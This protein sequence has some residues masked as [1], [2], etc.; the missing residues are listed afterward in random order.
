MNDKLR[1]ILL[2]VGDPQRPPRAALRKAAALARASG[3]RIELFHALSEVPVTGRRGSLA[4]TPDEGLDQAEHRL[5]RI[6]RSAPLRGC[7]VGCLVRWDSPGYEAIV[8]RARTSRAD[9][10]VAATQSHTLAERWYL[11]HTDWELIRHCPC[12]LLLVKSPGSYRKTTVLVA[13]DPFHTH[14][15]PVRLDPLLLAAG[16]RFAKLLGGA[17]HAFH[18]YMPLMANIAGSLGEPLVWES[19]EIERV[20]GEQVR[21]EFNRLAAKAGIPSSRRHI[22]LG[23]VPT[24][25][26]LAVRRLRARIVVMGAVSRSGLRRLLIGGTAERVLDR[27]RC[28]AL[29]VKPRGFKTTVP[30]TARD[31]RPPRASPRRRD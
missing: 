8:R 27:L 15:K 26:A 24:E 13:V 2:A 9:L 18:A 22:V 23:D 19:P 4:A 20:H 16:E 11:R 21:G 6:A 30:L 17:A 10:V 3:A 5:N 14:A 7:R 12:P 29:I 28:D 25:L 31:P 1:R